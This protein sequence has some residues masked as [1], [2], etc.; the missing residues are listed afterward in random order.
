MSVDTHQAAPG[1]SSSRAARTYRKVVALLPS[2]EP[3]LAKT[4]G[5]L[6]IP[7]VDSLLD[8]PV[9]SVVDLIFDEHHDGDGAIK[10]SSGARSWRAQRLSRA[11]DFLILS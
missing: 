10:A 3:F 11:K 8:L 6:P 4:Q 1:L 2:L 5:L 9:P 7:D